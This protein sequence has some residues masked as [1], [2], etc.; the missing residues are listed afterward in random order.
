MSG[1]VHKTIGQV[2]RETAA[3]YPQNLALIHPEF[4]VRQNYRDFY[5]NCRAIAKG[6]MAMGVKRGD[7]ISVWT[8]NIPEWVYLQ[9][10]LGM[11][12]GV[13]VTVNTSY[14]SETIRFHDVVSYGILPG[15]Q[16]L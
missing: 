5:D 12:G 2:I 15:H 3:R 13:L 6:L 8:T 4:G 14:Q 1:F 7:N 9:F 16:L 11:I 10:S